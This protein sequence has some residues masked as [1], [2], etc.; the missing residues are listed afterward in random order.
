MSFYLYQ[1]SYTP[2]AVKALVATPSDREAAARKLI[3]SLGGKLH[4]LFFAFGQHDVICLI[5]G[6]DDQMMA[7]GAMAVA[8]SGTVASSSTVKLMTP[9]EAMAAMQAAGKALGSY[10]PPMR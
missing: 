2:D 9:A 4:H 1:L 8:A 3:E 6:P 7:A 10:K 5:E